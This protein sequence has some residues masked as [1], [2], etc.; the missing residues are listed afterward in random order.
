MTDSMTRAFAVAADHPAFD[1]HFPGHP[2]LPGVAVLAE[3]LEAARA[4]P[5]LA[6][7]LGVEPRIPVVKFLSAVPPGAMLEADFRLGAKTIEWKVS[8]GTRV[9]ASGQFARADI[10]PAAS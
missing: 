1:G 7:A 5:V 2:I 3:V 9:V 8:E 10:A 4:D 6:A